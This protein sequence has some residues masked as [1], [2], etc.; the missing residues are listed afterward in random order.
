MLGVSNNM[1][2]Q[3]IV[4]RK[5]EK[6]FTLIELMIVVAIIGI[7]AAVAIP[8]YLDYIKRSK[9]SEAMN[10]LGG[11]K[12]P[13]D[14]FAGSKGAAPEPGE[15][16]ILKLTSVTEGKHTKD[17][18]VAAGS[19]ADAACYCITMKDA[20]EGGDGDMGG[21][22][23]CIG[24]SLKSDTLKKGWYCDQETYASADVG[25]QVDGGEYLDLAYLPSSCK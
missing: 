20:E 2:M 9:V 10:L 19:G 16:A 18:R 13:S 12:T 11:L 15:D 4:N 24:R 5:S 22:V 21:K 6:G 3:N 8:A 7:L 23:L 25:C 1:M 14:E 17:L